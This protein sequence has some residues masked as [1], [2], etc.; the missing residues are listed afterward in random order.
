MTLYLDCEFSNFHGNLISLAL[1]STTGKHWYRVLPLPTDTNPW[2]MENVV[3]FLNKEPDDPMFFRHSLWAYLRTHQ[4]EEIIA[5]WPEDFA[6]LMRQLCEPN[7]IA[8]ALQLDMRL[9]QSGELKP[10]IPHNALS[11]AIAL[12]HWH[13]ANRGLQ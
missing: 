9:I 5:D 8:P 7:G 6:H 1:A 4:D 12:M 2:V 3:P 13:V 10:D 11:D